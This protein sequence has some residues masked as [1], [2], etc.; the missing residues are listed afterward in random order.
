MFQRSIFKSLQRASFA[1][2]RDL[3]WQKSLNQ[4]SPSVLF[5]YSSDSG[6]TKSNASAGSKK[7][8][9]S[10]D[11]KKP[12]TSS[13]NKKNV[14][15][16]DLAAENMF[17]GSPRFTQVF[18]KVTFSLRRDPR[19]EAA[20]AKRS[21]NIQPMLTPKNIRKMGGRALILV[22]YF[23]TVGYIIYQVFTYLYLVYT[24]P[25]AEELKGF[26]ARNL[27]YLATYYDVL[28][29]QPDKAL[30]FYERAK[31]LFLTKGAD[32]KSLAIMH[33][34]LN[35]DRCRYELGQLE[36]IEERLTDM[37]ERLQ[38][39][40]DQ[41]QERYADDKV[42]HHREWLSSDMLIQKL[43]KV[44]GPT[45]FDQGNMDKAIEIYTI[46][47][48]A[49]KALKLSVA[50]SFD[51]KDI[52]DYTTY[53]HMNLKEASLTYQLGEAFYAKHDYKTARTLFQ[54]TINYCR[55]HKSHITTAPRLLPDLRSF[56]D[57][58][59]C[60]DSAAMVYLAR[61]LIDEGDSS[62]SLS[63]IV[64]GRKL[65]STDQHY[66]NKLC[67]RCESGFKTQL[68]RIAELQG[69]YQRALVRYREAYDY[70][71][72]NFMDKLEDKEADVARLEA[73]RGQ[74][75]DN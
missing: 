20:A 40:A 23:T 21:M 18:P 34:E 60:L 54:A 35:I 75:I 57:G 25:V 14:G 42:A 48:Q 51:T 26:K 38:N 59:I 16:D 58:W 36:G 39:M 5:F 10:S 50:E 71:Y 69:D 72:L 61:M 65:T 44:L 13:D 24:W 62:G 64:A 12:S 4:R 41:P 32:P 6:N 7:P 68:G 67:I 1:C 45:Y 22:I 28:E 31:K 3:R 46:G 33:L 30:P 29:S 9:A 17:K 11:S 74:M 53:D 43:V 2:K 15:R 56:V 52:I 49:V 70:L 8:G 55:G 73:M 63:W 19:A 47:L 27:M 66:N 37:L